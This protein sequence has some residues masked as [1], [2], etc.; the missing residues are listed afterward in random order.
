MRVPTKKAA[1]RVAQV[2]PKPPVAMVCMVMT[3]IVGAVR[4]GLVVTFVRMV[5][6]GFMRMV[7]AGF[8]RVLGTVAQE[9]G[10]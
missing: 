4:M 8:M 2:C 3:V 9:A 10:L 6:A 7:M 1:E 5:M